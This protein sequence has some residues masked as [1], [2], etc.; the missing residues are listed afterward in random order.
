MK[1]LK[2]IKGDASFREFYRKENKNL[3]SIIVLSR[4]EKFKNLVVY[5][6]I[7]KILK[8]NKILAPVLYQEN[9]NQDYIEI[10]DFGDD[11]IFKL[12]K[13]KNSKKFYY[14]KKI[15]KLLNKMQSIQD[16][17]IKNFRNK[18]YTI[19]K[20]EKQILIKEANLF[21]DWYIK[22]NLPYNTH[23]KFSK[24]FKKI[25]RKL[26]SGLKLRNN[27][28]VHRDFHVSNLMLVKN[29]LGLIDTQD[30]LIGNPAYDLVSLI[31]DVRFKTP[32]SFKKKIFNFYFKN[33]KN[34]KL[35]NLK[36]ISKYYQ[37]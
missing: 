23:N 13:K 18:N 34:I 26:A 20:Y 2:K 33:Q 8:K 5:D 22:K 37:F 15:I 30:A 27:V 35:M 10:Q 3:S 11:T 4:R 9:Y 32:K 12:L 19:P 29:Q 1:N 6:A 31:D 28:F 21:C 16:K 14:F 17:N 25:I 7:N 24:Q 36:T